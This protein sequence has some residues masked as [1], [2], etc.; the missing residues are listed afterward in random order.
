MGNPGDH[1]RLL[2]GPWQHP[3]L[4]GACGARADPAARW[5]K[6]RSHEESPAGT[7]TMG[8]VRKTIGKP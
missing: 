1:R 7:E 4:R 2:L 3:A 8:M 6:P 5:A